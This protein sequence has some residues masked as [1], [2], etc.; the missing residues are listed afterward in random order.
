MSSGIL[1]QDIQVSELVK[2]ASPKG[3]RFLQSEK[4][5]SGAALNWPIHEKKLTGIFPCNCLKSP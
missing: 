5:D 4:W 3:Y 2:R 1:F